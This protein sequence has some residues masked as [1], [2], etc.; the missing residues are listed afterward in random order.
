MALSIS[1]SV[2]ELLGAPQVATLA[3]VSPDGSPRTSVVWLGMDGD[4][5]IVSSQEGRLK[6]ANARREPRVSLCVH[7]RED[8]LRYVEVVG[9]AVVTPDEK[10]AVA[11]ALATSYRGPGAEREFLDLP[12]EAV[13]VVIRITPERVTGFAAD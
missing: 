4:D 6:V 13:R 2:R 10:R 1:A 5:V 9:T 8:P 11:A 12:A 3:T 7:D